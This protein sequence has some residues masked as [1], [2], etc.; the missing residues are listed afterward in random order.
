MCLLSMNV[1]TD[2]PLSYHRRKTRTVYIGQVAV[3][4]NNPIRCQSMTTSDTKNT[5]SVVDEIQELVDAGC[6]IVRVTVPT[7]ADCDNLPN[8]RSALKK[9]GLKVPL[10]ADIHFTPSIAMKVVEFVEKVRIN[11]GNFVDKKLFKTFEYTD[12]QYNEEVE[13]LREKFLPLVLKCKKY[14]ISMRIGTNH[15]SLSDRIMNRYGDTP[16]GMVESALE[17][18]RI[19]EDHGY[20]DLIFSMKA[21]NVC[22]MTAAYRL[23]AQKMGNS[24]RDYPFHLGVT[25][26]GA[27]EEGRI[28]SAIGIGALLEDG[29]GDTVRV[30]LTEDSVHEVPV[31]YQLIQKYNLLHAMNGF[32]KREEGEGEWFSVDDKQNDIPASKRRHT[33]T[34]N[35][36]SIPHG[37]GEPVRVWMGVSKKDSS[38]F[39]QQYKNYENNPLSKDQPLE[40]I[41]ADDESLLPSL[42]K[43]SIPLSFK[44]DNPE[45]ALHALPLCHKIIAVVFDKSSEINPQWENVVKTCANQG[46]VIEWMVNGSESLLEKIKKTSQLTNAHPVFYSVLSD[47]PV[48]AYRKLAKALDQAGTKGLIHLRCLPSHHDQPMLSAST[49]LGALLL[50]GLGDSLQINSRN[51]DTLSICD[52]LSLSYN[53]LQGARLRISKT[54][55]ISCPSCGRTQFDLQTTTDRIRKETRHLKGV[56]IAVMGCIVNGPGEMADADFGY[57]GT[58]PKKVSLYV[59][60][61]CVERNIPEESAVE[62][63]IHLIKANN[64][65]IPAL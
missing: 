35:V 6:E 14:G 62:R 30:S 58:G 60:K 41:E 12:S 10:V 34:V 49:V 29:I 55:Y 16:E 56:K 8:I 24:K 40:G 64:Q 28:K 17:F 42:S 57:V 59:G 11:P 15:G 13:R 63:L 19:C 2:R 50:D 20:K 21:S 48:Y 27:G 47:H 36:G 18:A 1:T 52:M 46:G 4:G 39:L 9:K 37:W 54:E 53:I 31:V 5:Q 38:S 32:S 61:E 26:A 44:T 45:K 7:Q 25:E 65:W 3:G 33:P 43:L 22:V 51:S 23:L